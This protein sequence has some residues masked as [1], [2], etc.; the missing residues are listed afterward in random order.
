MLP[1]S[2]YEV[3]AMTGAISGG[4]LAKYGKWNCIM[5][6]NGL[7]GIGYCFMIVA[8]LWAIYVGR[9]FAGLAIG[10]FCVFV[11]KTLNEIAPTEYTGQIGAMGQLSIAWAIAMP[12]TTG[13]FFNYA[14]KSIIPN[15]TYIRAMWGFPAIFLL[16]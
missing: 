4:Y 13:F 1:T 12:P 9:F 7:I 14:D 16:I 15:W 3:G 2:I 8:D 11:P 6:C 10:G 5:V